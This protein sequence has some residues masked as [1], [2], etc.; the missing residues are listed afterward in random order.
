M[1]LIKQNFL[2]P[3]II[4]TIL[5]SVSQADF[6]GAEASAGAFLMNP[7][8]YTSD[9]SD[10]IDFEDDLHWEKNENL[11]LSAQVEHPIPLLPNIKLDYLNITENGEGLITQR[12]NYGGVTL[13]GA[14]YVVS[15]LKL[16]MTDATAYYEILDNWISVDV[17]V[18]VRLMDM[19]LKLD[20]LTQGTIVKDVQTIVPMIYGKAQFDI[21]TTRFSV[22]AQTKYIT[23]DDNTLSDNALGA[24][25]VYGILGLEAGYRAI[26]IDVKMDDTSV[27]AD[28]NG[29][30][31]NL[32]VKF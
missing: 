30:Y 15:D 24:R 23:A 10:S 25:Y 4:A 12:V 32:I 7:T 1:K 6:I 28:F 27:Y 11:I 9:S 8:G 3:L 13:M 5:P 20:T 31:G 22:F 18:T 21:P 26:N 19:N 14:D 16:N 29:F 17:G 2:L